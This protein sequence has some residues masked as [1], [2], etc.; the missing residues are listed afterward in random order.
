MSGKLSQ[1]LQEGE[2]IVPLGF[3]PDI[4]TLLANGRLV[5]VPNWQGGG[6]RFKVLE[7]LAA[8]R[9]I[10]STFQGVEGV[11]FEDARHGLL[12]DAPSELA[13]AAAALLDDG[14]RSTAL[15]GAGRVLAERFRW[16]RVLEPLEA[17]YRDWLGTG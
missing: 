10:V 2:R 11:G 1:V 3:V 17:L 8:A 16:T 14:E 7:A 6:T 12:A 15:A 13:A 4:V 9:P 5:L